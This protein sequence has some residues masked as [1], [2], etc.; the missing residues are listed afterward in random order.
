MTQSRGFLNKQQVNEI[1]FIYKNE[2]F[3]GNI[4]IKELDKWLHE[5]LVNING[6][7]ETHELWHQI[8]KTR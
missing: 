8:C 3:N 4:Y 5:P 1:K 6:K 7:V 2:P